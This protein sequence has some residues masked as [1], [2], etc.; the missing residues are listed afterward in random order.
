M[1]HPP[2]EKSP[3]RAMP[4]TAEAEGDKKVSVGDAGRDTRSAEGDVKI[5]PQ[6]GRK[7]NVP[8][9]PELA[10]AGRFIRMIKVLRYLEP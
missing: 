7:R 8:A 4:E 3:S 1:Q 5:I 2:N 10:N 6:P 9:L